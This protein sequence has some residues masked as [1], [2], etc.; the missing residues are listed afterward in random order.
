MNREAVRP[1]SHR[2]EVHLFA[3][4]LEGFSE[5]SAPRVLEEPSKEVQEED[6]EEA[7]KRQDL[8]TV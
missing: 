5:L 2:E 3:R 7:S 8:E 1:H 4:V 6:D